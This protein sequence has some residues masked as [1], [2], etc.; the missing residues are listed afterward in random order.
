MRAPILW[1]APCGSCHNHRL[2]SRGCLLRVYFTPA[3]SVRHAS[4]NHITPS[5][6]RV[7]PTK[8]IQRNGGLTYSGQFKD[9]RPLPP[10]YRLLSD[11]RPVGHSLNVNCL[12]GAGGSRTR[13]LN[14]CN[15][16]STCVYLGHHGPRAKHTY[17]RALVKLLAH[18]TSTKIK[19]NMPSYGCLLVV[20]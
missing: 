5:R 19:A 16:P 13:V 12:G 15:Q 1:L 17:L 20:Q 9:D 8:T 14:V 2:F 4:C 6:Y 3:T 7:S 11:F 10:P 18:P